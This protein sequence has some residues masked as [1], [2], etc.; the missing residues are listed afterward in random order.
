MCVQGL[1][2]TA[3]ISTSDTV[4][5]LYQASSSW[6]GGIIIHHAVNFRVSHTAKGMLQDPKNM[7]VVVWLDD[8][9]V[10][11]RHMMM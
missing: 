8:S 3:E 10:A 11:S 2:E 9:T 6:F 7:H 1:W 4:C 5:S